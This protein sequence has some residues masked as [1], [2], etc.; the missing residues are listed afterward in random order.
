MMLYEN[1]KSEKGIGL[2]VKL[3]YNKET[4]ESSEFIMNKYIETIRS[5]GMCFI[6]FDF[7]FGSRSVFPEKLLVFYRKSNGDSDYYIFNI[8]YPILYSKEKFIPG[9][10]SSNWLDTSIGLALSM[11]YPRNVQPHRVWFMVDSVSNVDKSYF[12]SLKVLN[13]NKRICEVI[14]YSNRTSRALFRL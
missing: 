8:N 5:K 2:C 1:S 12:N 13:S 7:P 4:G 10:T 3:T 9:D 14:N 11:Y 6:S